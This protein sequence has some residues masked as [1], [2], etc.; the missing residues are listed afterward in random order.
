MDP[1]AHTL[2][3][4]TLAETRLKATT[5]LAG[6]ALML[7]ANAP[8][9]DAVTLFID[10]DLSFGFRRGWTHGVLAIVVLPLAL[11]AL[12]LLLD[13]VAARI[14]GRQ[15]AARAGPL[16]GL[17]SLAVLTHPVLD[18]LNTYGVRFLM[19]F[20][21]TWFYGDALFV[22]DP[23]VWLLMGT[24]VVLAHSAS[25]ASA[26]A[27]VVLGV[28]TTSLVTGFEVAP[29]AARLLW[30]L[31]VAGIV[32]LRVAG[33]W[34]RQLPRLAAICL[35]AVATYIVVMAAAS[36]VAEQQVTAWLAERDDDPAVEVMASPAPGN[37]FR[38]DIVVADAEHYHFLDLDWLAA[39]PI[40][41][42]T[43]SIE[44]GP[45]GPVTE[46]ALAAMQ[47]RGLA[48]WIRFP[49]FVVEETAEGYRVSI[50]DARYARRVGAGLGA[51]VVELDR[52]L[53]GRAR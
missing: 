22:V 52:D 12:L 49:A 33:H 34:R 15:P 44:R 16:L 11:A 2:V 9:I 27:W 30:C 50:S 5:A 3:G 39:E 53:R 18:W 13:R 36:R 41:I 28:A 26:S 19:P 31:G 51:A 46:A 42:A 29:P 21:G 37:P 25:R 1:L 24:T 43:R 48:A 8:D 35:S 10:R 14:R 47:V 4:A 32:W 7:G 17:C 45:P 40:R 6:P 20:D 38:R 23:W